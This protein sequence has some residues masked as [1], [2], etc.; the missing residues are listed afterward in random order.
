MD[1]LYHDLE[2][3]ILLLSEDDVIRTSFDGYEDV[4]DDPFAPKDEGTWY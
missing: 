4:K 3:E 1:K 2:I